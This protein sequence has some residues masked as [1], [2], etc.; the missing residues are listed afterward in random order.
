[1]TLPARVSAATCVF[2]MRNR[3]LFWMS[4]FCVIVAIVVDDV[5]K[6][7]MSSDR[8]TNVCFKFC[9]FLRLG[10]YR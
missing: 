7:H 6:F 4:D 8:V 10:G 9:V 2:E 3:Y 1:M 5:A